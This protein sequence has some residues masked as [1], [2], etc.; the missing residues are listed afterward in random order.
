LKGSARAGQ[1]LS[2]LLLARAAINRIHFR[3]M[4][5]I[6][7]RVAHES[8]T[9]AMSLK[10]FSPVVTERGFETRK[11]AEMNA[12]AKKQLHLPLLVGG[13]AAILVSGIVIASL[14]I[15]A[16]GLSEIPAPGEAPAADSAPAIAAS[17]ARA[18]RCSECGVIESTREIGISDERTGVNASGRLAPGNWGAFAPKPD[19][20]YEITIRLRDGSMRVVTDAHPAR[21]RHGERVRIIAGAN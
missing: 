10:S 5:A 18:Y 13:I 9:I 12:K 20:G 8:S 1:L 17:G 16:Q 21:W 4:C 6:A 15:S 2:T 19:R 3:A 7:Q 14:A 11:E